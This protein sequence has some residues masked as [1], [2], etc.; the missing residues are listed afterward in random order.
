[1][2]YNAI[3]V[4]GY[5]II[6]FIQDTKEFVDCKSLEV[7]VHNPVKLNGHYYSAKMFKK[8]ISD[9]PSKNHIKCPHTS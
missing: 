7:H 1:M 6:T 4:H 3:Q 8:M 9:S 5:Q 2:H